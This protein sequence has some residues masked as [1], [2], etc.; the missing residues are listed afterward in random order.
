[1]RACF[2]DTISST[3][4]MSRSLERPTM[5]SLLGVIGNSPPWYFPEMNRR[6]R[7]LGG[8]DE[9]GAWD[10]VTV[11]CIGSRDTRLSSGQAIPDF[12]KFKLSA[13]IGSRERPPRPQNRGSRFSCGE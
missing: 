3:R 8:P 10:L 1:M 11:S 13:K 7:D 6:A 2:R 5:I 4:T 9:F 12:G